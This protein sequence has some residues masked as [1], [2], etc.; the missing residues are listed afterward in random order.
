MA[1]WEVGC[2]RQLQQSGIL[3]HKHHASLFGF[4]LRFKTPKSLDRHLVWRLNSTGTIYIEVTERGKR[5]GWVG[6]MLLAQC[7]LW[8]PLLSSTNVRTFCAF[9]VACLKPD[10]NLPVSPALLAVNLCELILHQPHGAV[11]SAPWSCAAWHLQRWE[12]QH[13]RPTAKKS[14]PTYDLSGGLLLG[15]VYRWVCMWACVCVC[16]SPTDTVYWCVYTLQPNVTLKRI[17]ASWE[18][19]KDCRRLRSAWDSNSKLML[20]RKCE[21]EQD[22]TCDQ[23]SR[24]VTA[25]HLVKV[26]T[27]HLCRNI[28]T[29]KKE[30]ISDAISHTFPDL[31]NVFFLSPVPVKPSVIVSVEKVRLCT[32]SAHIWMYPDE[33]QHRPGAAFLYTH[34]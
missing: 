22:I 15:C 8:T 29:T 11:C 5:E 23:R 26:K 30:C 20:V 16:D 10:D 21:N 25:L 7:T 4:R 12:K 9:G 28:T 19:V 6:M 32:K 3:L 17:I 1:L 24:G 31:F 13:C 14:D 34:Y 18:I 27:V 33:L 2:C